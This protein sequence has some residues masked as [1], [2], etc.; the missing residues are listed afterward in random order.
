MDI[1][2][3]APSQLGISGTN[4]SACWMS[5]MAVCAG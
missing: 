1:P 2:F 5:E 4:S 3:L